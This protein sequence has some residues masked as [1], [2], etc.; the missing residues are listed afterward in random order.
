M[1]SSWIPPETARGISLTD[2]RERKIPPIPPSRMRLRFESLLYR[3]DSLTRRTPPSSS[4]RRGTPSSW[5]HP[6]G[7]PDANTRWI[8]YS[9]RV[10]PINLSC[11]PMRQHLLLIFLSAGLVAALA[12]LPHTWK[13]GALEITITEA[14]AQSGNDA[15]DPPGKGSG[16][17]TT[18]SWSP[19]LY[20]ETFDGCA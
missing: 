9:G 19:G 2:G 8:C 15:Q 17:S 10:L 4:P 14:R 7:S 6:T 3:R 18:P 1:T 5:K 13:H 11:D 16:T 20:Q 12:Q